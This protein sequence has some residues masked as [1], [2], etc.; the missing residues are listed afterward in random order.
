VRNLPGRL[1]RWRL[2]PSLRFAAVCA[3][4]AAVI[5]VLTDDATAGAGYVPTR[6]LLEVKGEL[7]TL[8]RC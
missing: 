7:P 6:A 1:G 3:L 4:D 2:Q 5:G 8:T